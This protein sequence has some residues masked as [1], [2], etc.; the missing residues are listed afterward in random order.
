MQY[1]SE[2]SPGYRGL[3]SSSRANARKAGRAISGAN[4]DKI[5]GHID[6][7]HDMANKA[8]DAMKAHTKALHAAADDL[9][10]MVKK[11]EDAAPPK[12]D[13]QDTAEKPQPPEEKPKPKAASLDLARGATPPPDASTVDE[14]ELE[15]MLRRL[16]TLREPAPNTT[17]VA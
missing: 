14:Q 9:G 4:A 3:M 13:A 10:S 7:V 11:P 5:Q 17:I 1:G 8:M 2:S 16:R 6:A 12:D 15:A